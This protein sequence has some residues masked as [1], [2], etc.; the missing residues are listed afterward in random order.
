MLVK[1]RTATDGQA[2]RTSGTLLIASSLTIVLPPLV[3]DSLTGGRALKKIAFILVGKGDG[4]AIDLLVPVLVTFLLPAII[5]MISGAALLLGR[6]DRRTCGKMLLWY[7]GISVFMLLWPLLPIPWTA[8]GIGPTY[9]SWLGRFSW[10][11]MMG[12][13]YMEQGVV[14]LHVPLIV[15]LWCVSLFLGWRMCSDSLDA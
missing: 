5:A 8:M 13:T 15:L 3:I 10:T 7:V 12:L 2:P 4:I 14:F 1:E 6:H 11:A 9:A